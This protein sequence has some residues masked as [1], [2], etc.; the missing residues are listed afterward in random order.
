V[1]AAAGPVSAVTS[2]AELGFQAEGAKQQFEGQAAGYAFEAQK[3]R[4]HAKYMDLAYE[5]SRAAGF[6]EAAQTMGKYDATAAAMN[7]DPSSPT[8][9]VLRDRIETHLI[10]A[11]N[12]GSAQ[13][14]F[15]KDMDLYSA[16]FKDEMVP[17]LKH[18]GDMAAMGKIIGGLSGMIGSMSGM[19]FG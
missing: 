4:L 17:Y 14:K 3:D 1:G 11:V 19:K 10:G 18:M 7:V 6:G 9:S 15:Q 2:M 5:Q 13:Y 16:G 12:A 8:Q